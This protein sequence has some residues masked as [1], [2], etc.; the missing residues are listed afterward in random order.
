MLRSALVLLVFSCPLLA[1]DFVPIEVGNRWIYVHETFDGQHIGSYSIDTCVVEITEGTFE[2]HD[3]KT[4]FSGG[5]G[6]PCWTGHNTNLRV[7]DNG[8]IVMRMPEPV[9]AP[10]TTSFI[11]AN[12]DF[13]TPFRELLTHWP[14]GENEILYLDFGIDASTDDPFLESYMIW[15]HNYVVPVQ[16]P[17]VN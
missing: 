1:T 15:Y 10:D 12:P 9:E 11:E 2:T 3:G 7:D 5:L 13:A 14:S 17:T 8:N 6:A 16:S 4:Y